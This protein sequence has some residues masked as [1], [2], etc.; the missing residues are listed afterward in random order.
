MENREEK[1]MELATGEKYGIIKQ[2]EE[3]DGTYLFAARVNDDETDLT[4]E[5]ALFKETE[6]DGKIMV[7][8][9]ED[10][11]KIKSLELKVS[12]MEKS[13]PVEEPT[14]VEATPTLEEAKPE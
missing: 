4:G 8:K 5:F 6:Q 2:F 9:I 13:T 3:A 7:E 14:P 1:L 12:D 11:E 10:E